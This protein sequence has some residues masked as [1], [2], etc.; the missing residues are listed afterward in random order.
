MVYPDTCCGCWQAI[1]GKKHFALWLAS[2]YHTG[3]Q[4]APLHL[5]CAHDA[6]P[7]SSD[8]HCRSAQ[9]HGIHQGLTWPTLQPAGWT[10]SCPGSAPAYPTAAVRILQASSAPRQ[11]SSPATCQ[12]LHVLTVCLASALALS[13][14]LVCCCT[15]APHWHRSGRLFLRAAALFVRAVHELLVVYML[16]LCLL[17]CLFCCVV[18]LLHC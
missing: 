15:I 12:P 14:L 7:S 13:L 5:T 8:F 3:F 10:T 17:L 2:R 18:H 6:W 4:P 1:T 9:Q 11:T 16:M